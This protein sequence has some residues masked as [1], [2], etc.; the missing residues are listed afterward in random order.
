V[1][2]E[3]NRQS[4]VGVN[5]EPPSADARQLKNLRL[6]WD[7]V[8]IGWMDRLELDDLS[9]HNRHLHGDAAVMLHRVEQTNGN[10]WELE[11][12]VARELPLPEPLQ[13]LHHEN[14]FELL[15]QRGVLM[16][17]GG[18]ANHPVENGAA[19]YTLT[20]RGE[21]ETSR[22]AKLIIHYPRIRDR[23]Q[24]RFEFAEIPLPSARPE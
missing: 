9:P 21:D 17:L 22:P 19:R 7:V 18:Q 14:A 13:V 23:R 6:Q 3:S 12:S 15:D 10:R 5:I 4:A 20:F 1:F 11:L 2:D 16:R 24:V 8:A